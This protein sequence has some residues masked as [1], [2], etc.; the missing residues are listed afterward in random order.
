MTDPL[1]NVQ[2]LVIPLLHDEV[3]ELIVNVG[4]KEREK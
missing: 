4:L 3:G 2:T 1:R